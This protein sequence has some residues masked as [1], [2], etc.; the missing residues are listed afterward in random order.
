MKNKLSFLLILMAAGISCSREAAAPTVEDNDYTIVAATLPGGV[1]TALGEKTDGKYPVLWQPGDVIGINGAV[2]DPLDDGFTPSKSAQFRFSGAVLHEPYY[3]AYPASAVSSYSAGSAILTLPTEQRY[4]QGSFDPEAGLLVGVGGA[5]GLTLRMPFCI[6]KITI[7]AGTH[8]SHAITSVKLKANGSEKMSGPFTT[9][10]STVSPAAGALNYVMVKSEAGIPLGSSVFIVYPAQEYADGIS[11]EIED[12]ERHYMRMV[13]SSAHRPSAGKLYPT[14]LTFEPN[15]TNISGSIPPLDEDIPEVHTWRQMNAGP[16]SENSH[17]SASARSSLARIG[18]TLV[19]IPQEEYQY[20]DGHIGVC[21]PRFIQTADGE[22]L[23]FYHFGNTSTWAGNYSYYMRSP[24]L[25]DWTFER[26]L[27]AIKNNQ[28]S[29]SYDTEDLPKKFQRAYAGA[30][31]C[32]LPDGRIL[33]V[34]ATRALS[35]YQLRPLDNGL[36]IRYSSDGGRNWT[37]DQLVPVGTCWE[38]YPLVLPDGRIQIYYTDASPYYPEG[39]TTWNGV[40]TTGS[41]TSYIWSDDNG[42]SW[43]YQDG[44]G[45]H[46]HAFRQIRQTAGNGTKLYTDQMPCVLVLNAGAGLAGVCESK[47]SQVGQSDSYKLSLAYSGSDC[48]WGTPD[49]NGVLPESRNDRFCAGAA[50]YMLQFPSGETILCY[51]TNSKMYYRVGDAVAANFVGERQLLPN[52]GFWGSMRLTG[53]HSLVAGIGGNKTT[54]TIQLAQFWLNHDIPAP[55]KSVM[56]DGNGDDW[57]GTEALFAGSNGEGHVILRASHDGASLY[58]LAE[59]EGPVSTVHID[60]MSS[61]ALRRISVNAGGL[62]SSAIEGVGAVCKEGLTSDLASGFVAEIYI[63]LSAL[64]GTSVPVKLTAE[65]QG[66]SDSFQT[67]AD[68]STYLP[69]IILQ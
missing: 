9:D 25:L 50:P 61:G 52:S 66:F 28:Q 64:A 35:K 27:F 59:A 8:T 62:I 31:L 10:Y 41:G 65:G 45:E 54:R 51:N 17:A 21:Y 44:T 18:G 1:R 5:S 42:A 32:N 11:I 34:A 23:M 69:R 47:I 57:S 6:M 55:A 33:A 13:S 68:N 60:L 46:L 37:D 56:L 36:A 15:G 38:P 39:N 4:V 14:E 67:V 19:E 12:S 40:A 43:H 2:S 22:W 20:I 53:T 49:A 26:K 29:A 3:G 30:D 16:V 58:L 7:A 24:D 63:P 48:D